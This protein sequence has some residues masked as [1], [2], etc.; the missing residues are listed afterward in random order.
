MIRKAGDANARVPQDV[1]R[2]P[3][4]RHA[5]AAAG[6][7]CAGPSIQSWENE[8][9]RDS[10]LGDRSLTVVGPVPIASVS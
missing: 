8:G 5:L 4:Q 2:F 9:C 6:T 3:P 10:C 1:S 7:G